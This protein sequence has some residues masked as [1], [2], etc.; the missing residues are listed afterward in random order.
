MRSSTG[1]PGA[2]SPTSARCASAS[3]VIAST[4]RAVAMASARGV[5]PGRLTRP[6]RHRVCVIRGVVRELH[7]PHPHALLGAEEGDDRNGREIVV[8]GAKPRIAPRER[9]CN[10]LWSQRLADRERERVVV[11]HGVVEWLRGVVRDVPVQ[12]GHHRLHDGGEGGNL[13]IAIVVVHGGALA[14]LSLRVRRVR[15]ERATGFSPVATGGVGETGPEP[16]CGV[17]GCSGGA[18]EA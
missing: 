17:G 3:L 13:L 6:D 10:L 1:A 12:L 5:A 18:F 14:V 11:A 15:R 8:R 16:A 2:G 7:H 9:V 4:K